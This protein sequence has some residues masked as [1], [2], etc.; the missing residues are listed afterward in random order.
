MLDAVRG[1]SSFKGLIAAVVTIAHALALSWLLIPRFHFQRDLPAP[2]QTPVMVVGFIK[3]EQTQDTVP[4]PE[5]T[6]ATPRMD[7]KAITMVQFESDDWGDISGVIASASA[8]TLSRFQPVDPAAFAR[9]AGLPP[10]QAASV[11]LTVEV[12]P[13]GTVGTVEIARGFG[14]VA[15]DAAAVAYGRSLR[16]IPGTR[17]HHA[18]AM[19]ITLPV[20]LVWNA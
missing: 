5:V 9:R 4:I 18:E 15:V 11:V 16:W 8:P 7:L 17:G 1:S 10:G 13:D 2:L 19:R 14:D 12:L 6:L 20:T 3:D